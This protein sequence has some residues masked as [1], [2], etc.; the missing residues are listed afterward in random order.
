MDRVK[1][2]FIQKAYKSGQQ[3]PITA[4]ITDKARPDPILIQCDPIG[5][6]G[7]VIGVFIIVFIYPILCHKSHRPP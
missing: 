4:E 2:F 3:F 6:R 1:F 7:V 5:K